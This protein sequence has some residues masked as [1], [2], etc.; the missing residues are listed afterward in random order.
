MKKIALIFIAVLALAGCGGASKHK[1]DVRDDAAERLTVA[2]VQQHL[3]VGM[4]G[5]DV[6]AALGAPNMITTD[7]QH[8]ETWV[9]DKVATERSSSSS[10]GGLWLVV[11]GGGGSSSASSNTQ[12]TLTII[13]KFDNDGMVR[14]YSYR[15]SSF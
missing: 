7:T 14:D 5:A 11:A 10:S 15:H 6:I 8:R 3:K 4:S 12:R 13:I 2:A 9:Y 1:A